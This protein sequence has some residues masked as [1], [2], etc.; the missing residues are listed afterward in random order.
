M[1]IIVD[2]KTIAPVM[3]LVLVGL[4]TYMRRKQH[5]SISYLFCFCIF[6]VYL[7]YVVKYTI[8]PLRL[9]SPH[10]T[11]MMIEQ[12]SSWTQ[13]V[14]LVPFRSMSVA[15][16]LSIQGLGNVLL[17]LPFGFGLPFLGTTDLRSIAW[18]G[19]LFPISIELVQ[20]FIN[21]TYGYAVR[22]A[23]VNDV[24]FNFAGVFLGFGL[25]RATAWLYRKTVS[26]NERVEGIWEHFHCVLTTRS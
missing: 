23:E 18:K 6:Y 1:G 26:V 9:F 22:T 20:F 7:L 21:V 25:L 3:A 15:Y 16:V 2:L 5:K 19:L 11:K 12:G 10:Y 8:F 17:T 4:I 14:N 13:G 24:L